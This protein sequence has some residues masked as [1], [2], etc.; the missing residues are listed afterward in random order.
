MAEAQTGDDPGRLVGFSRPGG[1]FTASL[2]AQRSNPVS[3]AE[4]WIASLR[5]Q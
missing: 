4:R 2:R 1:T 3:L 5:S